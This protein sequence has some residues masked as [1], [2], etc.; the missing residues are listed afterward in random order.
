MMNHQ[1]RILLS[2]CTKC[3]LSTDHVKWK[4]FRS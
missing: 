4:W 2:S 3:R 1:C